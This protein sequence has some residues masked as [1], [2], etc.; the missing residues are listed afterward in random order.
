M[1]NLVTALIF[2]SPKEVKQILDKQMPKTQSRNLNMKNQSNVSP[3]YSHK[4]SSISEPKDNELA[5]RLRG[6][7]RSLLLKMIRDLKEYKNKY[8]NEV[9]K[10]IQDLNKKSAS[11]RRNS[12]GKWKL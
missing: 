2:H 3:P 6:Q 7:F 5:K 9:R 11:W 12:A 8:K 10:S 1:V 4:N